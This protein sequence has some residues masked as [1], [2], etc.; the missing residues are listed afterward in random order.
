MGYVFFIYLC[1]RLE[2]EI[3]N[4]NRF[5]R[6]YSHLKCYILVWRL[7]KIN[8]QKVIEKMKKLFLVAAFA[9]VSAFA[10]AQFAV[11][12]HTLYGTDVANLGIG[13]RARYDI[14]DQ[15]RADGNFNY[16]FKKNNLEFWDLNANLHYL[17][18]ITD[19]FTAYPLG[20]LG[21]VNTKVTYTSYEGIDKYGKPITAEVST[22][23]GRLGVN[24]GG[25]VDF[26]LTDDLYL[27]GEVKYQIVSGYN[28]AV[29]S[30]GIVYKF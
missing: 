8:Y 4:Q 30:A 21:Y 6:D 7:R 13:V 29:M 11:G 28:Q 26:A 15:F 3:D 14:N 22:S 27:N 12:V 24:L 18:N 25:G 23:D 17:F 9:M 20:G 16:Y 19:K 1:P 10:S 5:N 2:R